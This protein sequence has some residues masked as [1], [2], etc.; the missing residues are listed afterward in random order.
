MSE[1]T[2]MTADTYNNMEQSKDKVEDS[3]DEKK[4]DENLEKDLQED[5]SEESQEADASESEVEGESQEP[6]SEDAEAESDNSQEDAQSDEEK[7]G[8]P[9]NPKWFDKRLEREFKKHQRKLRQIEDET[10][11]Q[12]L[13]Q[14][15][16][17]QPSQFDQDTYMQNPFTGEI[18]AKDS[19][20]GKA[21]LMLTQAANLA[22]QAEKQQKINKA[23]QELKQKLEKGYDK[24]DDYEEVVTNAGITQSMLEAAYLSEKTDELLYN[25]AKYKPAEIERI[26]KLTPER[27]FREMV[28]LETQ[29]KQSTK[30]KIVKKVPE[31][32]SKIKGSGAS[33]TDESDLSFEDVLKRRRQ[34][35]RDALA[36]R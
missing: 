6:D 15:K 27:Q 24:F 18:V 5:N 23:Q 14:L 28:L 11:G 13:N 2:V 34:A 8:K 20:E 31:P 35:E 30:K 7:S 32:P 26:S 16:Q 22:E 21:A 3:P 17:Q 1:S 33:I 19:V 12:L 10:R 29:M 4:Q 25:L 36:G 9:D